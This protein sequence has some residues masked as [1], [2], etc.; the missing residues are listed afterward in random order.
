MKKKILCFQHNSNS[1]YEKQ[2]QSK[3]LSFSFQHISYHISIN[4]CH[5]WKM[6]EW[7]GNIICLNIWCTH[8]SSYK[9]LLLISAPVYHP[10]FSQF[11]PCVH[12]LFQDHK[13]TYTHS[14]WFERKK[15]KVNNEKY[16]G[17]GFF[18]YRKEATC[19][20]ISDSRML[21]W[22]ISSWHKSASIFNQNFSFFSRN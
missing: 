5:E 3:C 15:R 22:I 14:L 6:N 12:L 8:H 17:V 20:R 13:E 21:Q 9:I 4:W 2:T 16:F 18:F 7:M 19:T 1:F 11:V 10:N